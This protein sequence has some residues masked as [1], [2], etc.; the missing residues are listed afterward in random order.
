LRDLGLPLMSRVGFVRRQM[1]LTMAGMRAGW[2]GG[3]LQLP[4]PRP[5]ESAAKLAERSMA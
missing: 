3:K 4:A 2:L 1:Q 5:P